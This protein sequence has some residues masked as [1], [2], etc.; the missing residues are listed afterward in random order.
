MAQS[1]PSAPSV[2]RSAH[3]RITDRQMWGHKGENNPKGADCGLCHVDS[4]SFCVYRA[5]CA[6][7]SLP[8]I[9]LAR[10]RARPRQRLRLLVLERDRRSCD[11]P[12][13]GSQPTPPGATPSPGCASWR[14]AHMAQGRRRLCA[15][16]YRRANVSSEVLSVTGQPAQC[17]GLYSL[18]GSA[19]R[20]LAG[21]R[22]PIYPPCP[23]LRM[24]KFRCPR[25]SVL[26][27]STGFDPPPFRLTAGLRSTGY[28]A[29]VPRA[30]PRRRR[31][32]PL[33]G[34]GADHRCRSLPLA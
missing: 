25:R 24:R 27:R 22:R 21:P 23:E 15:Q 6:T 8:V 26:K 3:C 17:Y 28:P 5:P 14:F 1:R 16:L 12:R 32:S 34:I 7:I 19:G 2:S 33:P 4:P 31:C 20:C 13:P 29:P 30:E 18:Q 10:A 9:F 11:R